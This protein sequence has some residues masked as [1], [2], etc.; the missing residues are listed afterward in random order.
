MGRVNRAFIL[1]WVFLE[2]QVFG[3]CLQEGRPQEQCEVTPHLQG[4]EKMTRLGGGS[5][6]QWAT[7]VQLVKQ[8]TGQR[9]THTSE[10]SHS[11]PWELGSLSLCSGSTL[12]SALGGW[13]SLSWQVLPAWRW[14]WGASSKNAHS[15][16]LR[17]GQMCSEV[18]RDRGRGRA[19]M[20]LATVRK[21]SPT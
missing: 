17:C 20:A 15:G 6:S 10:P 7:R 1:V 8:G 4:R 3:R 14:G 18:T 9:R 21:A 5:S 19:L 11:A 16:Q 13:G 2:K 12:E